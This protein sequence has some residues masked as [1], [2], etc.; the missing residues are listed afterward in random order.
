MWLPATIVWVYMQAPNQKLMSCD[1]LNLTTST[2]LQDR[3]EFQI[4]ANKM[5]PEILFDLEARVHEVTEQHGHL[6][7]DTFHVFASIHAVLDPL[8]YKVRHASMHPNGGALTPIMYN[9][10]VRA[11][12]P[13]S[14]HA[15]TW[16]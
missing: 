2:N 4:D 8:K 6:F 12:W 7:D 3:L 11:R 13:S 5:T 14:S 9:C 16:T 1:I 15:I 10:I